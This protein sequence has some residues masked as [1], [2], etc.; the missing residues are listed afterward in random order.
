[1]NK[2]GFKNFRKF[3]N[4]PSIDLGNLTYLVGQNNAG[5]STMVKAAI[6]VLENLRQKKD[7]PFGNEA[8]FSLVSPVHDC[9]W[10]RLT[11]RYVQTLRK[12]KSASLL[13]LKI[14]TLKSRWCRLMTKRYTTSC[15]R[16]M[17]ALLLLTT[18]W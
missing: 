6:L 8:Y 3:E 18:Y 13:Q 11:A 7:M 15:K 2:I 17:T 14:L 10:K 9:M 4:F 12:R 5:K 1:M 16:K